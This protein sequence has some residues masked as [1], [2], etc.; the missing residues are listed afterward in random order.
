[1]FGY[2]KFWGSHVGLN[3]P[4]LPSVRDLHSLPTTG[5]ESNK[6]SINLSVM[7]ANDLWPWPWFDHK[8]NIRDSLNA[9]LRYCIHEN[10]TD[11]WTDPK[12]HNALCSRE[13]LWQIWRNSHSA[14]H[15]TIENATDTTYCLL[16]CLWPAQRQEENCRCS[17]RSLSPDPVC[18]LRKQMPLGLKLVPVQVLDQSVFYC[19]WMQEPV[20]L[21][22]TII[23][24]QFSKFLIQPVK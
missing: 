21:N 9:F 24:W 7:A 14:R 18:L 13:L 1:M 19:W 10:G 8:L 4:V 16:G 5:L 23:D 2:S 12:T 6:E 20:N 22:K 17:G 3:D 15:R 11:K